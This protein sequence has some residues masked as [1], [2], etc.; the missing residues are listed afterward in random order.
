MIN[1]V[2]VGTGDLYQRF[3]APSLEDLRAEGRAKI[4]RTIDIIPRKDEEFLKDVEH[5]LRSPE[6]KLSEILSDLKG[7]DPIVILGHVNHLHISDAE[8]LVTQGF[9]VMIEKPY[10]INFNQLEILK[11]LILENPSKIFLLDYYLKRKAAP[12]LFLSGAIKKNT[13]YENTEKVMRKRE[14]LLKGQFLE[15]D[16]VSLIG[17]PVS[18]KI[19]ILEGQNITGKLDHRGAHLFHMDYG[20]GMLQD[21]GLHA[22]VVLFALQ[23]YLGKVDLSFEK[24]N[25]R[26]AQCREYI[27]L[28]DKMHQ[29]PEEKISESY[30]EMNFK[31]LNQIP[32]EI[33][34]GKY[35]KDRE[36]QKKLLIQGKKG[37][38]IMDF[39]SNF[40][41]IYQHGQL[42]G[43]T[44]LIN[45]K[46]ERYY[47]VIRA[48]LEFFEGRSV[49]N[50]NPL[51][52][53]FNSQEFI[54]NVLKKAREKHAI[55]IYDQGEDYPNIFK[56]KRADLENL[57]KI[58]RS[59]LEDFYKGYSSYLTNILNSLNTKDLNSIA[60][61]FLEARK[62]GNTIYF[63]G[64]GGSASTASHFAQ[65]LAEVGRKVGVKLFKSISLTDNVSA[66]TSSANDHGYDKVFSFQMQGT[67]KKNDVLVAISASG[68]SPNI[69]EAVN[70]AKEKGGVV[71]GLTGFDG[72]K[73]AQLSDY[74]LHVQADKGEY[75]PVEDLHVIFDHL[76]TSYFYYKLKEEL[77]N[78]FL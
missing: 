76:I 29:I 56:E 69:L 62:N 70:F 36:D 66:I 64:N 7:E 51:E 57:S 71:V 44:E 24:G 4:I 61:L 67:F 23:D 42:K 1:V 68:N 25:I 38:I 58:N 33:F 48:A 5:K 73:L 60:E 3:L 9:R 59:S 55:K 21:L 12:L 37:K 28:A 49:F 6:Q 53:M 27:N 18:V 20:G 52:L 41:E 63:I 8:D 47:P 45:T 26:L 10:A 16:L 32:V 65:D 54:L 30:A 78:E 39:H 17:E 77:T 22:A 74:F 2:V 35:V 31:T 43:R 75:G 14:D 40:L 13:F 19:D 11:K 15:E 46:K 72:G 34:V 50:Q